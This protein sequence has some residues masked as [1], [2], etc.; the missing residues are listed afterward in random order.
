MSYRELSRYVALAERVEPEMLGRGQ[1]AA[2]EALEAEHDDLL[3]ALDEAYQTDRAA[4]VRIGVAVWRFRLLRSHLA[5]G[6]AP[7]AVTRRAG[8]GSGAAQSKGNDRPRGH[9]VFPGG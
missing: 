6:R 3:G 4:G 1:K 7:G 8:G 9:S 2:L 5:E